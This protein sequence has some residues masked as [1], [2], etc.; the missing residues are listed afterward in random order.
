MRFIVTLKGGFYPS[1][2][3][4]ACST[5]IFIFIMTSVL[6]GAAFAQQASAPQS[7]AAPT[8]TGSSPAL[9][10]PAAATP[11]A[12]TPA[13]SAPAQGDPQAG[14]VNGVPPADPGQGNKPADPGSGAPGKPGT[15][16]Q[17][18]ALSGTSGGD[19]YTY[20]RDPVKASLKVDIDATTGAFTYSY[21]LTIPPG[22]NGMLPGLSLNYH[23]QDLRNDNLV[24]YGW[25]LS[26]PS[27][28][29]NP[30]KGVDKLYDGADDYFTSS[31]SGELEK[32]STGNY[33]PKVENGDF[34][35]YQFSN[36]TWTVTDKKGT[37][38]TFGPDATSRQD[39]GTKI[40]KWMI[41]KIQDTNGN[42]V[43][44]E[45]AKDAGQI[46]PSKIF[47]TGNGADPGV[48]EIDFP[49]QPRS[50]K[51]AMYGTGFSVMTNSRVYEIQA[52]V[53]GILKRKFALG[54]NTG[55]NQVR[56][57]LNSV[58][59]TGWD[60]SGNPTTIPVTSFAYS[61]AD[62][63][64]DP[65]VTTYG[66]PRDFTVT[67]KDNGVR[68]FEIDGDGYPD[69]AGGDAVTATYLNTTNGTGWQ[70]GLYNDLP[71]Y[72]TTNYGEDQGTRAVDVNGDG[73]TD[74]AQGKGSDFIGIRDVFANDPI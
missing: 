9:Q 51:A 28:E 64:W 35:K 38:Y 8:P 47:Y 11:A 23:S 50:D 6:P 17:V 45:Y 26:I 58:T 65:S 25:S 34:L 70:G 73:L 40:F 74:I 52:K 49:T 36:N 72:F 19:Q 42:Y 15:G 53:Q 39:S 31:L 32:I 3:R 29:R 60:E 27:I 57:L 20:D 44:Y 16:D 10:T 59:E 21:P 37:V 18:T 67:G 62:K 48:F 12:N 7:S 33:G 2:S 13:A 55:D 63:T 71:V 43:R 4:L 22:R 1:F 5:L 69:M 68:I 54:Y 14:K 56:S 46:Y 66:S 41:Q 30:K 24:G 61:H